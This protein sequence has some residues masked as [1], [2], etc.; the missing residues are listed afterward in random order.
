MWPTSARY[1]YGHYIVIYDC[2]IESYTCTY[3]DY[4]STATLFCTTNALMWL[5]L[6]DG[7]CLMKSCLMQS[8]W[9]LS[10]NVPEIVLFLL[11]IN[12]IVL[13][14]VV[15]WTCTLVIS[16]SYLVQMPQFQNHLY[17]LLNY[18]CETYAENVLSLS[19]N[20][21]LTL[22]DVILHGIERSVVITLSAVDDNASFIPVVIF[23]QFHHN[24]LLVCVIFYIM[25]ASL[26][27]MNKFQ[28]L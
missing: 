7:V 2:M 14:I 21:W 4:H 11:V 3:C 8:L 23:Q 28:K 1:V 18:V 27:Y 17:D 10:F 25:L 22:T 16:C 20:M 9:Y 24:H 26:A 13:F 15:T 19:D 5:L 12:F 6:K